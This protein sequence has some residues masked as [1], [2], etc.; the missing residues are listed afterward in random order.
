MHLSPEGQG[1]KAYGFAPGLVD[2]DM[3]GQIRASGINQVSRLARETLSS[4]QD[5]AKAIVLAMSSFTTRFNWA[6][7]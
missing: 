6:R 3:Q 2:T 4:P 1:V 7:T 5:A